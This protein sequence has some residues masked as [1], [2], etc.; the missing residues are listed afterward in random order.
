MPVNA[1]VFAESLRMANVWHS[2]VLRMASV[3]TRAGAGHWLTGRAVVPYGAGIFGGLRPKE[4]L[5]K[6]PVCSLGMVI[7]TVDAS[8]TGPL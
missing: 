8:T 6:P 5:P 4:G 2:S 3:P 1:G 7:V